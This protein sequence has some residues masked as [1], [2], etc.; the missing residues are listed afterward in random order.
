VTCG[1]AP[2]GVRE[3]RTQIGAAFFEGGGLVIVERGKEPIRFSRLADIERR[4][5]FQP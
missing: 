5:D 2:L 4:P 3:K 1:V